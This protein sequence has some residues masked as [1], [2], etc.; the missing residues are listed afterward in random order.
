MPLAVMSPNIQETTD[1]GIRKR[2]HDEFADDI[3][4]MDEKHAVKGPATVSIHTLPELCE[5]LIPIS[6]L[7]FPGLLNVYSVV[8]QARQLPQSSPQG[9]P[10]LTDG[11]SSTPARNSPGPVTPSKLPPSNL[12]TSSSDTNAASTSQAQ[13]PPP[14]K[15]KKLTPAE[16]EAKE[17]EAAEKKKEQEEK[18]KEQDEMKAAKAKEKEEK[19]M[20]LAKEREEQKQKKAEEAKLKEEK[21]EEKKRK[22]QEEKD[23]EARKQP[24]L[25]SFFGAPTTP[26][27]LK[28][29]EQASKS[30]Q[31]GSPAATTSTA[32]TYTKLFQPFFLK[33]HTRLAEPAT[34][35]DE[36]TRKAKSDTLDSF[37]SGA[38]ALEPAQT[39]KFDFI[40]ALG[41]SRRPRQRGKLF[42]PVK[43]IMEEV[44]KD[45]HESGVS[46][47]DANR[48]VEIAQR[49]LAKVPVKVISFSQDVRPPYYGTLTWK[50]H[51][52]GIDSMRKLARRSMD[53]RLKNLE[54]DYDSEAEWQEDEEGEDL[55]LD[56]DEEEV[57]DEDDMDGFLDDSEDVGLARRMVVNAMEPHCSGLRFEDESRR[58]TT[59]ETYGFKLEMILGKSIR[60]ISRHMMVINIFKGHEEGISVVDPWSSTYWAPEPKKQALE[61]ITVMPP[62]PTPANAF[63]A[64]GNAAANG[65]P[66]TKVVKTEILNDVK[67][68]ILNNKALS[69]VG[70]IDFVFQQFRDNASRIEVK[71]TI[72]L[73]AERKGAGKIKEWDLKPGHEITA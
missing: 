73:V 54:Y 16:R 72:E 41:F 10:A 64:I 43:G 36:E 37:I 9:S 8:Q 60:G 67:K 3:A 62:P 44:F 18:K 15:R 57:D 49:K 22:I 28:I 1:N 12:T 17:R 20:Q 40:E 70:I 50:P 7:R 25:K 42:Q 14:A 29:D 46:T 66:P 63:A 38:H 23:K 27:K 56:D 39:G 35:M 58:G 26:K 55:D 45:P 52:A 4:G 68:A 71:N 19:S 2:S 21:K 31:K 5:L 59:E 11:T 65:S 34:Q 30:P 24:K 61:N 6:R 13:N 32:N 53:R 51:V 47:D 33:E 69:K 48:A